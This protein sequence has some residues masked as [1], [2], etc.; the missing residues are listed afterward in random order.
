MVSAAATH[1]CAAA[2]EVDGGASSDAFA[3]CEVVSCKRWQHNVRVLVVSCVGFLGG[4]T[5]AAGMVVG[6]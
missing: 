6:I 4:R 5:P 1:C 3:R 2:A